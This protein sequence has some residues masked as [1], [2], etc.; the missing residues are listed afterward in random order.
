MTY[1]NLSDFNLDTLSPNILGE[2]L[3][4]AKKAYY[5][6]GKPIMDDHTYDTLETILK[7]K[8]PYHRLFKKVGHQNFDTGFDKKNHQM[9]M[10]SE[11]KVT[12]Y[13]E[14]KKY[15]ELKKIPPTT[16]FVVQPKCDGI[17]LEII[18]QNG[19]LVEAITRG[20]G[21]I[22]DIITQNVIKMQNVV[23]NLPQKFTGSVRTEIVVTTRDFIKLNQQVKSEDA[24]S[25]PRNAASGLAQRLDGQYAE[26]CSLYAVDM[27]SK[28]PPWDNSTES[29]KINKLSS[30][31][32]TTV[33][34]H[35]CHTFTDIEKIYQ[36]FLTTKRQ[37]YP[38]EIDGLV[39]KIN[40]LKLQEELGRLNNRPKGQVAY[41]FPASSN[42]SRIIA[43]DW[44]V[45][46]LGTITPVAQIEPVE[47]SGAIITY[48]S[49]ANLDLIKEKNINLNDIV[50]ISRRGD[51]IPHIE[52]VVTKVTPGFIKPPT[53]CPECHTTL[54]QDHKF[55]KC[56]NPVCPAQTLGLLRL[57]CSVLD[58]KGISEKTIA[59]LITAGKINHPGDFYK[60]T[61]ADFNNLEGLGEKSGTNIVHQIQ[62][63]RELDLETIFHAAAIPHFSHARIRQL[64]SA[65]FNTPTKLLN[66]SIEQLETLPGIQ[67]TL[68]NKIYNGIHLRRTNIESILSH[69]TIKNLKLEIRNLT[70]AG[71]S[72]AITGQLSQPRPKIQ[73]VI[74][75]AGGKI[76][77][78][79]TKT[80]SYLVTNETDSDSSKF[81]AAKK[82]N[83]PI[84]TEEKLYKFIKI[85]E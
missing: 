16:D 18:Y 29:E 12:T 17:S 52:T 35:L 49:L 83:I 68:A 8:N 21:F 38:Y 23:I 45:G 82:F 39:I 27:M 73:S 61:V 74:E 58:I 46:P 4:E 40:N 70:L 6:T 24:Y 65:G 1:Y 11:N 84:I 47:I 79:I 32:F 62:S 63:K 43:I 85:A 53:L 42:L 41:K 64:I 59:K 26:F 78:T 20:D 31:G 72:F 7:Q 48:A 75:A 80:T 9:A 44:Q 30:L 51:V 60:L 34:S 14:L 55:L 71:L 77:N 5:T 25:N 22:G 33:E 81:L 2:I 76:A 3:I 67:I 10:G 36:L 57:F 37:T 19:Q 13:E 50:K 54:I 15:F 28:N 66:I 56:P 69:V